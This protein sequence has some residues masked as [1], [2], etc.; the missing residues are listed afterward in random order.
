[1]QCTSMAQHMLNL[2]HFPINIV[3]ITLHLIVMAHDVSDGQGVYG[4]L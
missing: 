2:Y 1:M 3:K 4:L